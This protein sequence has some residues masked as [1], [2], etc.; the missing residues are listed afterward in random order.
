MT[1]PRKITVLVDDRE[2]DAVLFP[3]S[4][5]WHPTRNGKGVREIQIAV[6]RKRLKTGDYYLEKFRKISIMEKK[7]SLTEIANNTIGGGTRS[8]QSQLDRLR[9]TTR[10]PYLLLTD[11]FS[12]MTC[13]SKWNTD[14][15]RVLSHLFQECTRRNINLLWIGGAHSPKARVRLGETI[16]RIMLSHVLV[17]PWLPPG[18]TLPHLAQKHVVFE[19]DPF[20]KASTPIPPL[21]PRGRRLA[22]AKR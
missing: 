14:P 12:K 21:T 6:Q 9:E 13:P 22:N 17:E 11:S 4:I 16:L 8:F 3:R 2:K 20:I 18:T 19:V 15:M 10:Y 5:T 1:P 7:G